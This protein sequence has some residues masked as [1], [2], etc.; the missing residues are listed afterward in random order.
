MKDISEATNISNHVVSL[1]EALMS[2]LER[3][4]DIMGGARGSV[5]LVDHLQGELVI[6]AKKDPDDPWPPHPDEVGR[7]S[8]RVGEGIVGHVAK[9]GKPHYAPIVNQDKYFIVSEKRSIGLGSQ[10]LLAVPLISKRIEKGRVLGVISIEGPIDEPDFFGD[11]DIGRVSKLT[12]EAVPSIEDAMGP[13]LLQSTR[14]FYRLRH[15]QA[16]SQALVSQQT[17]DQILDQIAR[18]AIEELKA[19]LLTLYRWDVTT[20]DFITPPIQ[21][22][23]FLVP[24]AMNSP[25]NKDDAVYKG[26]HEWG[27]RFFHDPESEPDLTSLKPAPPQYRLSRFTIREKVKSAA[28]L[29]LEL[30]TKPVGVLCVN[31]RRPHFFDEGERTILEIFANHVAIAIENDRLIRVAVGE[32][33][34]AQRERLHRDLHDW[35]GGNLTAITHHATACKNFI[36]QDKKDKARESFTEIEWM[37]E[38]ALKGVRAILSDL[39]PLD[40]FNLDRSLRQFCLDQKSPQC[41]INLLVNGPINE[42]RKRIPE[43]LFRIAREAILNAKRHGQAS[44]I[45][46]ILLITPEKLHLT[47]EDNGKG[48]PVLSSDDRRSKQKF[49]ITLMEQLAFVLEGQLTIEADPESAG[50]T[51]SLYIDSPLRSISI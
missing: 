26:F 11:E 42:L 49:G 48:G 51:V 17:L 29:R 35:V 6:L 31:W 23:E 20:Q 37:S 45:K 7:L 5:M 15:I 1:R 30:G 14:S 21:L 25:I 32:A 24:E 43:N 40:E 46:V 36:E 12:L 39:Q 2:V 33:T 44:L 16:V 41:S 3:A 22:G 47:I 4:L 28:I 8:F 10:S 50:W 18:I 27:S 13:A 19:D 38:E 9:T 34:A